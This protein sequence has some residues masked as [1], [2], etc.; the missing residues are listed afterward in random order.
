MCS[1]EIFPSVMHL[2][3]KQAPLEY[4]RLENTQNESEDFQ[5]EKLIN[6]VTGVGGGGADPEVEEHTALV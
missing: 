5:K 3:L 4:T 1:E 2:N 6:V